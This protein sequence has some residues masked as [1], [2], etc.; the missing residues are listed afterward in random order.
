MDAHKDG[1]DLTKVVREKMRC[2]RH[3]GGYSRLSLTAFIIVCS[4]LINATAAMDG[5]ET[6]CILCSDC[7]LARLRKS[8]AAASPSFRI[9]R[10]GKRVA[11]RILNNYT[12]AAIDGHEHNKHTVKFIE[13]GEEKRAIYPQPSLNKQHV[14]YFQNLLRSLTEKTKPLSIF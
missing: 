7:H 5:C 13:N 9:G 1:T 10:F 14:S 8:P 2:R 3:R 12:G 4:L 6:A 11:Y